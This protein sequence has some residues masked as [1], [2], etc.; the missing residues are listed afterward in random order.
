MKHLMK[1]MTEIEKQLHQLYEEMNRMIEEGDQA[2]ANDMIEAKYKVVK[3]QFESGIQGMEQAA[4]LDMLAQLR[5]SL[6]EAEEAARLLSE[7]C[8]YLSLSVPMLCC[9]LL[10]C[11]NYFPCCYVMW[12]LC[13]RYQ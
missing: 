6:G 9:Y 7:V 5:M 12:G 11:F 1:G 4:M 8:S 13:N 2:T 10:T 3:G